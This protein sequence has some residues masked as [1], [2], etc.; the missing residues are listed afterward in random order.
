MNR[1][2]L[3]LSA[4][5]LALSG[6]SFA[7]SATEVPVDKDIVL[8]STQ[9]YS[10]DSSPD[11][12]EALIEIDPRA[13]GIH[14]RNHKFEINLNYDPLINGR[15]TLGFQTRL[16]SHL[17]LD[18]P[19]SFEHSAITTRLG[20]VVGIYESGIS[21]RWSASAGVGLKIRLSEWMLKSAFYLEPMVQAGYYSEFVE[22]GPF[23]RTPRAS[24][25]AVRI[26]PG[27]Y[28]GWERVFDSGFVIDAK[29]G[30]EKSF[31]VALGVPSPILGPFS[32][33]PMLG[34]GYSW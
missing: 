17:S 13:H 2:T 32:I 24:T 4:F 26:R 31:D 28:F 1:M 6:A 22:T 21:W 34:V 15:L 33:V 11:L 30:V 19:V 5:S 12:I 18:V 16:G 29:L 7:Q 10:V 8:E 9:T 20:S 3:I 27:I 25:Q 14:A 23:A